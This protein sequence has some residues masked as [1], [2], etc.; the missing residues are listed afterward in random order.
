[1][2]SPLTVWSTTADGRVVGGV[3]ATYAN[4]RRFS[5]SASDSGTTGSIAGQNTGYACYEGFVSF[6]TSTVGSGSTVTVA[7]LSFYGSLDR[8][9]VDFI[10]Q[11]RFYDWGASL[12]VDDWASGDPTDAGSLDEYTLLAAYDTASGWPET[13]AYVALVSEAAFLSNIA[14]T[15]TTYVMT[16]S[17][18][19]LNGDVPTGTEYVQA[20]LADDATG[21]GGTDRDPKLYVEWT[22]GGTADRTCLIQFGVC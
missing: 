14:K 20:Y 6:D 21:G 1:M 18:R 16:S 2:A 17:S 12:T 3:D 7:T 19:Q 4:C 9:A 13:S 5:T 15:G 22:E 10:L 8:S 11:A